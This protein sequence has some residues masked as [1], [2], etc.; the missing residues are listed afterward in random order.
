MTDRQQVILKHVLNLFQDWF[1]V[2][3]LNLI[4]D[5]LIML[6]PHHS[7]YSVFSAR[8]LIFVSHGDRKDGEG[9]ALT[10]YMYHPFGVCMMLW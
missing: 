10:P 3:I 7:V 2:V 4:Q 6:W 9:E 5:L 1:S 8:W